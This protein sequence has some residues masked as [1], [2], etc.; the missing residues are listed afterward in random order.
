MGICCITQETQTGA[1]YQPRGWDGEGA[2]KAVQN[3]GDIC[4]PM[5]DFMLSFDRK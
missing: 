4:I 3:R 5:T 1:L 2:G